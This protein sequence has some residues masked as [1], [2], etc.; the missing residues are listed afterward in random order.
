MP[1]LPAAVLRRNE[2]IE[3]EAKEVQPELLKLPEESSP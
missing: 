1:E 3:V 2:S